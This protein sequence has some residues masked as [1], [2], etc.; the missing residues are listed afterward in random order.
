MPVR[1]RIIEVRALNLK[2]GSRG[3]FHRV[4]VERSLPLLRRWGFDVVAFGPSA[5]DE[6]SFYVIRSFQD[7]AERQSQEDA[8]Y[9]SDD[10]RSGPREL[11]LPLI[12]SYIDAVF[13]LDEPGIAALRRQGQQP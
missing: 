1:H 4:F 5:H 7:L 9:G 10:W 13:E 6:S 12:E 2:P 11:L 3:E 8:F